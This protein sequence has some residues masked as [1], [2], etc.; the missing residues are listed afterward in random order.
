MMPHKLQW[1]RL[2]FRKVTF[3]RVIRTLPAQNVVTHAQ[4]AGGSWQH[5]GIF[6]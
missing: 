2:D 6:K 5:L 4:C 3:G 1:T